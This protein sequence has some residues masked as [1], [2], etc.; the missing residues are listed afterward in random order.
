MSQSFVIE[1]ASMVLPEELADGWVAVA[2]GRIAEVGRGRAPER[3]ADFGG[4]LL[5]PGLIE[6]HTDHLESH[7][8]PRPKV[9][10]PAVA[11]VVAYDAQIVASGITTVFDSLRIGNDVDYAPAEDEMWAVVDAIETAR[12]QGL[13]RCE[14]LTHLRCEICADG[15]VEQAK[16]HFARHAVHMISLMDHTPGARQFRNLDAWRIYYG[17]KSN[18]PPHQLDSFMQKKRALFAANYARHRTALVAQ[19]RSHG[20]V[21]A[22]HDDTTLE[23]VAESVG[24]GV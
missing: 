2:D 15:V 17:G 4:D 21:V 1:N 7:L 24:D 9:R 6:L 13:L 16:Q 14:H 23:H 20:V 10:W 5:M 22:S 8:K 11:A 19:A 12:G 3:G 18:V